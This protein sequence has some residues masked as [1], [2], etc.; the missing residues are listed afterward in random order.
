MAYR[1][2]AEINEK[3]RQA[4]EAAMVTLAVCTYAVAFP[5]MYKAV[6]PGTG[7][8]AVLP[9]MLISWFWGPRVGMAASI[10]AG[11]V[12]NPIL[13]LRFES[14]ADIQTVLVHSLPYFLAVLIIAAITG[15]LRD[16]R[17]RLIH[18]ES[19]RNREQ[20]EA[21]REARARVEELLKLKSA[22]LNNMSHELRTPL[23]AILGFAEILS[24][25]LG[26]EQRELARRIVKGGIRLQDTLNSILDLAQ[27]EGGGIELETVRLDIAHEVRSAASAFQEHAERKGLQ[28]EI[29]VPPESLEAN[30][31]RS[32]FHRAVRCLVDNA[33]KF[34]EKGFVR[35]SVRA[36]ET[37][38]RI[39]V[40]DSGIGIS[41]SFVP[42]VFAEFRQESVG[43]GRSYEGSGL[44][45]AITKRLVELMGGKIDFDSS[46]GA[47]STFTLTFPRAMSDA[48]HIVDED[49][50][51]AATAPPSR[52]RT[53]PGRILV[54]DDNVDT[55]ALI[56]HQL[57][58]RYNV[59]TVSDVETA[60][61]RARSQ[62]FDAFLLDIN[63]GNGHD[64]IDVLHALREL[65]RYL[66]VPIVA[67]SAYA[68][69]G[70]RERFLAAGFDAYLE[71]PFTRAELNQ[72]LARALEQR[73]V[74]EA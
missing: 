4:V 33:I 70:D 53:E 26:P 51:A 40:H 45:L 28:L 18:M 5:T 29:E 68:L 65:D 11:L 20:L 32:S 38:I 62:T 7:A 60:L 52:H 2:D 12:L 21:E 72:T 59:E 64:G 46:Q 24:E 17:E 15:R 42:H 74:T 56:R 25:E 16:L 63:L 22:F 54:L 69:P 34:T 9:V 27:L 61:D 14:G 19:D 6:G 48:L 41:D 30:L 31:D 57:R 37:H 13:F 1:A 35:V 73:P 50:A 67:V 44:G 8:L 55:L 71:K 39:F 3:A 49:V 66:N 58:G 36:D 10:M 47:G 43:H 23:T